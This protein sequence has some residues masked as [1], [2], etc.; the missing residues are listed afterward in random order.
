MMN[1]TDLTA[2][3]VTIGEMSWFGELGA[4]CLI[5]FLGAIMRWYSPILLAAKTPENLP[6]ILGAWFVGFMVVY[7][8]G[9]YM[10]YLLHTTFIIRYSFVS[11]VVLGS[12]FIATTLQM[13]RYSERLLLG[14]D[15]AYLQPLYRAGIPAVNIAMASMA[16]CFAIAIAL[17]RHRVSQG[18]GG[19]K[20]VL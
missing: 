10:L 15:S 8:I 14:F 18:K 11:K 9:I 6:F 7:G 16:L 2:L 20:W 12:Y 3:M 19:L 1:V 13:V 4:F 5:V 17:S